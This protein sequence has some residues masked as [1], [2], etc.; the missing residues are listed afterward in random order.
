MTYL[1][2]FN[3]VNHNYNIINC[4]TVYFKEFKS[5]I[6]FNVTIVNVRISHTSALI[7]TFTSIRK[8]TLIINEKT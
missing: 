2:Y 5:S 7:R 1:E 4:L 8:G 3:E 6:R